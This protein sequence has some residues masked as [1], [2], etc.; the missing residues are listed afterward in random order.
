MLSTKKGNN[1]D[2][3]IVVQCD[4]VIYGYMAFAA[5]SIF[6]II[7]GVVAIQLI[8]MQPLPMDAISF[9]FI[10]WNFSVKKTSLLPFVLLLI[11]TNTNTPKAYVV[12]NHSA[13]CL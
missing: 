8:Q 6:F 12:G 9:Y 10:L 1:I 4:W 7:T 3:L 2:T 13:N 11:Q 5:F